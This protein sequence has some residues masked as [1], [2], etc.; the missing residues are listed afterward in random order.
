MWLHITTALLVCSLVGM[1]FD[2][3]FF[4]T[5]Y[6]PVQGVFHNVISCNNCSFIEDKRC[7]TQ[8]H[9]NVSFTFDDVYYMT[10][11]TTTEKLCGSPC[12]SRLRPG[13]NITVKIDPIRDL[14]SHAE[15]MWVNDTIIGTFY[16]SVCLLVLF[17]TVFFASTFLILIDFA[18]CLYHK[19]QN[20][21]YYHQ[22]A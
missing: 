8:I 9:V 16:M 17:G 11:T 10:N 2:S 12:C 1:V 5:T 18:I 19:H 22:L 13:T 20:H 21:Q 7:H 15:F 3:V 6:Y 14:P 4:F